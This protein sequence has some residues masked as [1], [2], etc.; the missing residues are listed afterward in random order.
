MTRV[1]VLQ[2]MYLPWMGYFGLIEQADVF[3]Y[4]DDVQF[5]RRSWQ[6]RNRIKIP[7]G[8]FTWL[9]VTV[10]KDFG[11]AINEVTLKDDGWRDSHWKSISH[12]YS[13][14]PYFDEY[15]DDIRPVYD[16]PWDRLVDLD[17][18][19]IER[20]CTA[21]GITDTEFRYA[22]ELD[23]D[24][25]KTDRL[26]NVLEAVGGDEYV[27]GPG[28]REYLDPSK[29]AAADID[30]Y[31]HEFEHPEYDQTHGEFVSHLSAVDLLFHLGPEAGD[32]IRD[33]ESNAL[34]RD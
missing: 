26:V 9:T 20:L 19:L 24:G 1:V 29:F 18:E 3:V 27:S 12:S 8:D 34:V 10:E 33:A 32:V 17:V 13:S 11:Q 6:R 2:P 16:Q 5:V 28:A 15:A 31:W 22:S 4:Y 30:L 25:T 14:T 7:D 23:A 21:F